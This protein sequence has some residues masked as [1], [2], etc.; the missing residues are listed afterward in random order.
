MNISTH[1]NNGSETV[2]CYVWDNDSNVKSYLILKDDAIKQFPNMKYL[3][4]VK[5]LARKRFNDENN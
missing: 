3:D 1:I 2:L 5:M 4:S